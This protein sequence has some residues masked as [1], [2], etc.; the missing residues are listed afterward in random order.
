[1]SLGEDDQTIT[2]K[3][4]QPHVLSHPS[5]PPPQ[6]PVVKMV[7]AELRAQRGIA[8]PLVAMN[9]SWFAKTTITTAFLSRLGELNLA[10]GALG[11]SF[12]NVTGLSVLNGLCGAMEP[13]CGQAHGAKN[14][15]LL[16]KTHP[17]TTLLLLMV[18]IPISF[19]WLN[20]DKI[21]ILLGQQQEIAIVAKSYV[22]YLL[23]NLVVTSLLCPLRAYLSSQCITLPTLFCSAI[24]LA[25]H[26]PV[27]ILLSKVMGLRGVAMAV[28]ITDLVVV[29]L[30]ATYVWILEC[31]KRNGSR[32]KEGGWWDQNIIDWIVLLKLCGSCCL[33][34]CLEWWCYEILVLLAGHLSSAK[35]SL[36]VLA[37]V[38]NFDYLLYS[39]MLSLGTS[40]STRVSN[41]LGANQPGQAYRSACVSMAIAI[42]TGSIGSLVMVAARGTWGAVFSH[43]ASIIK[44]VKKMMLL[45]AFVEVFNFPLN[46]CGGI[47]RGTARPWLGMYANLCGFYFIA[48][49]LDLVFAFKLHLGLAGLFVGLLIGVVSCFTFL[50]TFIARINWMDEAAKAQILVCAQVQEVPR[51]DVNHVHEEV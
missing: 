38:L 12:T 35:Q 5:S 20:I 51:H 28:W 1:M 21:L 14:I 48:L 16:H 36:G 22:S 40:V 27:N 8:L 41:E 31:S 15:K 37:I 19:L 18:T 7:L 46:I 26:V 23:P 42:I 32:W 10:A 6:H 30:L 45:M 17:M 4:N 25:F 39:V 49:P 24:S 2:D 43:D 13:L 9:L 3:V 33:N 50:L 34:T 44:G 47:V 11:L 29:I